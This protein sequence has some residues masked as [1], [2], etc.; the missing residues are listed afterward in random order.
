MREFVF[1]TLRWS[2]LSM[3]VLKTSG[4]T[5]AATWPCV[6]EK[7]AARFL[8]RSGVSTFGDLTKILALFVIK[9]TSISSSYLNI[10]KVR[11][12]L[13]WLSSLDHNFLKIFYFIEKH[14]NSSFEECHG[15]VESAII[16]GQ[17]MKDLR[18]M[19]IWRK[20]L[21][22]AIKKKNTFEATMQKTG[23]QK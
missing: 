17:S 6:I 4:L 10:R 13:F 22:C 15:G 9:S 14:R 1:A 11:N 12:S 16:F 19:K 3:T 5:R 21:F 23:R 7:S 8:I 18:T 20:V 2:E